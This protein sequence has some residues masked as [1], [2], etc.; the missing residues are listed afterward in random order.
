MMAGV[1]A[2]LMLV[3]ALTATGVPVRAG[4][5]EMM[6]AVEVCTQEPTRLVRL[7][8]FDSVFN[9][10]VT[11][12]QSPASQVDS[13][14]TDWRL[15]YAR[16]A[17]RQPQDDVL[18]QNTGSAAGHLVTVAAL[19]AI[20]PR[21]LMVVQCH[22][23]ITE[24]VLMMPQPIDSERVRLSFESDSG[25][26]QQ[27][28]RVRDEGLVVSGGRGL[29]AIATVKKLNGVGQFRLSSRQSELDGLVFDLAGLS[30]SL[31]PLREACG[32]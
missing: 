20:P 12:M 22:N 5:G 16:E 17:K 7:A 15:A 8:C 4:T 18:Y 27:V 13:R 6:R 24:L 3:L 1:R 32:W 23:N 28:W 25:P 14:P 21:P 30:A 19:G 11:L 9:T 10:P 26:Q 29:P 2:H 31:R